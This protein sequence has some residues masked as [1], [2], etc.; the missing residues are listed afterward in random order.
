MRYGRGYIVIHTF[1]GRHRLPTDND[2]ADESHSR[3]RHTSGTAGVACAVAAAMTVAVT[4]SVLLGLAIAVSV[5]VAV[6]VA[7]VMI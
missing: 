3:L 6:A 2:E 7:A 5:L 4:G 1:E